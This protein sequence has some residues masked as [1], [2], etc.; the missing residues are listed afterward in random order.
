MTY[1][2]KIIKIF[3]RLRPEGSEYAGT[4]MCNGVNCKEC[5]FKDIDYCGEL[6]PNTP[7]ET[8]CGLAGD[9]HWLVREKVA[10]NPNTPVETLC[11]L[12]ED[13]DWGVRV[14]AANNANTPAEVLHRLA[15]DENVYVRVSVANNVNTP[16]KVLN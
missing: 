1:R 13:A 4:I 6:N 7:A 2:Q 5:P 8:L 11:K 16:V 10:G 14:S 9:E 15:G 3:D 12:A